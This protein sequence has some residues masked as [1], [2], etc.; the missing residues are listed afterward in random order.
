MARPTKTS[1]DPPPLYQYHN[2][3][4]KNVVYLITCQ[5]AL[6]DFYTNTTTV[7]KKCSVLNHMSIQKLQCTIDGIHNERT[8]REA[9]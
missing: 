8:T 4:S 7:I 1:I 6:H 2:C 9:L 3:H 5:V